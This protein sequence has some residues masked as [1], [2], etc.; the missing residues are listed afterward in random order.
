VQEKGT[1]SNRIKSNKGQFPSIELLILLSS[2]GMLF[3]LLLALAKGL[4]NPIA[5][6]LLT[7]SG[8]LAITAIFLANF[9][10]D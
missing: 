10:V 5:M 4:D 9:L 7:I 2:G 1:Q 6:P 3:N 8:V